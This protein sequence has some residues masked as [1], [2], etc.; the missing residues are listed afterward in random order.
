MTAR[1]PVSLRTG[2][3]SFIEVLA[4]SV[5]LIGP[6]MTPVLIAPYMYANAGNGTWLAYVFGGIMLLFVALNLNQFAKRSS[7]AGSMYGYAAEN[8]GPTLGALA[9]WSLIWAYV[10]VGMAVLGAMT[11]F[12]EQL[13]SSIGW[14]APEVLVLVVMAVIVWQL[15]Y[16]DV[17]LS[18]IVMLA[19][20][21]VSVGIICVL[22]GIVFFKH[23]L[24]I[25]TA[26]LHLTGVRPANIGLG[27]ATAIFSLVGFESATAFGEEAQRPKVTIPRAVIWSVLLASAFFITATYAEIVGLRG[28]AT[29]LDKL[30]SPL[31]SLAQLLQVGYLKVPITIG[32]LFSAFSVCL[33]CVSTAG[34]IVLAMARKNLF[35]Q[36]A[37]I[38]QPRHKTPY[39][40]I[41]ASIGAMLLTA[42]VLLARHVGPE[43]IFNYAGTLSSFGFIVIYALIAIAAP[44]YVR[45]VDVLRVPD[46]VV[47]VL[48][49]VF[50]LVPAV[51]LF[52][53]VPAPPSNLFPYAFIAYVLVG[54]A[55]FSHRLSR[56]PAPVE[57]VETPVF[58]KPHV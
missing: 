32:A 20:E 25:D 47:S 38:I 35:P 30:S 15:A 52:Y 12:V 56:A 33:A 17:Q 34:R 41:A 7:S 58:E 39:V 5:A 8:L 54:W 6:S 49:V 23:G 46:V 43:D 29:S 11:L 3:L 22:V 48:A 53:P 13:L 45:R 55:W 57:P 44:L 24:T 1:E 18:A 28:S 50:L 36:A 42:V 14:H 37:A 19:L 26:Q 21:S 4:T 9:G 2:S 16:R 40:G 10:L 51:T 27:I 31:G